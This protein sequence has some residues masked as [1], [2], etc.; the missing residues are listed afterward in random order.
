MQEELLQEKNEDL[1]V[2]AAVLGPGFRGARA[3]IEPEAR[4]RR[5]KEIVDGW[6]D[7]KPPKYIADIAEGNIPNWVERK[8][9]LF[10]VGEYADKNLRVEA[11]DLQRL[12]ASLDA[13]V[14]VWIEHTETPLEMGYLTDIYAAGNELFGVLSL[15]P[16]ADGVIEQSKAKSLS[17]S[18]SKNMDRIYE[19]SI[20][21]SPRVESA[22]LFCEDFTAAEDGEWKTKAMQL[23]EE[24]ENR[25]FETYV[26][27]LVRAGKLMPVQKPHAINLLKKA[28]K[29]GLHETVAQFFNHAP[30]Q[31]SFGEI[32]RSSCDRPEIPIEE[33]EF[34][35]QHFPD[36]AMS[37]IA[38]RRIA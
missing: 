36:L 26:D 13:P 30:L 15:T 1:R 7:G 6:Q 16:E 28:A 11:S 25:R 35:S 24:L 14:P 12:A 4:I 22:R 21:A 3:D 33:A 5:A 38:K 27:E 8:A 29:L 19:V 34:Y 31:I 37:E 10:E 2:A 18:V 9:K 17:L 32:A 23:A 20:V